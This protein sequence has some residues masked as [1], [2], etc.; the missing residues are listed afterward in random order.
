MDTTTGPDK[1]LGQ[2]G[3]Y[4]ADTIGAARNDD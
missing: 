2:R 4:V 3:A 1:P